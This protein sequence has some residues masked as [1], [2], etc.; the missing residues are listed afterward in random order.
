VIAP[1]VGRPAAFFD[2]S[3]SKAAQQA[4]LRRHDY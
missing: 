2:L 3:R 1:D 4:V